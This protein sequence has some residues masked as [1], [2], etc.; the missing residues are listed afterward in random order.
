MDRIIISQHVEDVCTNVQGCRLYYQLKPYF[1]RKEVVSVSFTG[2][3][4]M[5]SSFFNSSFGELI[6]NYGS[7]NFKQTIRLINIPKNQ[8]DL[9]RGYLKFHFEK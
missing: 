5:S 4:P 3:N 9:I 7:D 2:L 1:D 8:V 6:D